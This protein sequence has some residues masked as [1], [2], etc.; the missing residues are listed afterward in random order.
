MTVLLLLTYLTFISLGLPDS[1]LG[2]AWPVMHLSF[3]VPVT[4]AGFLSFTA[5]ACTVVSSLCAMWLN[6][7]L[8]TGRT[9]A[10]STL[11]TGLALLAYSLCLNFWLL[12]PIA[13]ALGLGGG[14]IDSAL[15][16]YVALHFEA[17][18]MSFL[19]S[20]WGVGATIGPMIL[21][22]FIVHSSWRMG[23]RVIALF[24]L[25]LCLIQFFS[26]RLWKDGRDSADGHV[27]IISG[28]S[29]PW[30]KWLAML[31]FF[32][33]CAIE[34]T[35]ILWISTY[36]VNRFN[37]DAVLAARASSMLFFGITGGRF[38][39]GFVATRLGVKKLIYFGAALCA[40]GSVSLLFIS[41]SSVALWAVLA[42]GLGM[43]P[44]YPDMIHRTPRRF[45]SMLSPKIIGFQMAAAYVGSTCVPPLM[46]ILFNDV[47]FTFLP[48]LGILCSFMVILFTAV[49]EHGN[50]VI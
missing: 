25:G 39:S 45:G 47:S 37:A 4:Y 48:V 46:G 10:F 22:A 38:L 19:H 34:T 23:Y 18:H 3:G 17:R 43:A 30:T 26:I 21:S 32:F 11:L 42:M 27:S 12:I 7:H 16:N 28:G 49:I 8:G 50:N 29:K 13:I 31:S 33:Y 6:K 2:A 5:S 9:V 15:N 14:A 36:F 44:I 20:F 41:T 40:V 24:Q 1:L 35:G